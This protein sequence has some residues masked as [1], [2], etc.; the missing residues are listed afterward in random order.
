[1]E[2]HSL[3][4]P[5]WG[6]FL[7]IWEFSVEKNAGH[8]DQIL[9]VEDGELKTANEFDCFFSDQSALKLGK[10]LIS[11]NFRK[12]EKSCFPRDVRAL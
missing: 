3:E 6:K 8:K 11:R 5:P 12:S 7:S 9:T 4:W 1:M 10:P 2:R